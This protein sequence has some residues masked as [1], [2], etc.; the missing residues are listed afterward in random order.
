MDRNLGAVE[1]DYT[2]VTAC[3]LYYQWGRKDPFP[4]HSSIMTAT[5][6]ERSVPKIMTHGRL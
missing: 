5:H 2:K 3:G 1:T 4:P 6:T